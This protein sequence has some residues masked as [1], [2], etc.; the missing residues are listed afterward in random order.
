MNTYHAEGMT[1]RYKH[2]KQSLKLGFL[3]FMYSPLSNYLL[4]E[5]NVELHLEIFKNITKTER[6]KACLFVLLIGTIYKNKIILDYKKNE[7]RS[8]LCSTMGISKR[9][10]YR[11]LSLSME[12]GLTHIEGENLRLKSLSKFLVNI[13]DKLSTF[14]GSRPF[15]IRSKEVATIDVKSRKFK[16]FM[17][18]CRL[19]AV[20]YGEHKNMRNIAR[21]IKK[22]KL[23]YNLG[24]SLEPIHI[25]PFHISKNYPIGDDFIGT[26]NA[27]KF[28]EFFKFMYAK[29]RGIEPEDL[30]RKM[31]VENHLG[32]FRGA[33]RFMEQT[34]LKKDLVIGRNDVG[35]HKTSN[36]NFKD[37]L[38]ERDRLKRNTTNTIDDEFIDF[39]PSFKALFGDIESLSI[40]CGVNEGKT[41]KLSEG[42]GSNTRT[43]NKMNLGKINKGVFYMDTELFSRFS[44]A[45]V[46]TPEQ[47]YKYL[48]MDFKAEY[49][50]G[51]Y[52][53]SQILGLDK[54]QVSRTLKKCVEAGLLTTEERF[55]YLSTVPKG[56]PKK[57]IASLKREWSMLT[58]DDGISKN[59]TVDRVVYRQGC[60]MYQIETDKHYNTGAV[61]SMSVEQ[62]S[63]FSRE[64]EHLKNNY[65]KL[66]LKICA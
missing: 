48:C 1:N 22:S 16:D 21:K 64:S 27:D 51:L 13:N 29:T 52:E 6:E 4:S 31:V 41:L 9:T 60:L 45:K 57:F 53:I 37:V 12:L 20:Q 46:Y 58:S 3:D 32:R 38:L 35:Y 50:L 17:L 11:Y 2:R 54:S 33:D 23:K 14:E 5:R 66:K 8:R 26:R 43:L 18:Y 63:Y 47:Y 65:D 15:Y 62:R 10:Y 44:S 49:R 61:F 25:F 56:E 19:L 28:N 34:N 36:K 39:A 24:N 55:V 40:T 59:R 30:G 42:W 7:V